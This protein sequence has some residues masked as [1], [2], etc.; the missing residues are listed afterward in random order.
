MVQVLLA[1]YHKVIQ[2][3]L[4]QGLHEPLGVSV[5]VRTLRANSLDRG[6]LRVTTDSK[7]KGDCGTGYNPLPLRSD[8]LLLPR[9]LAAGRLGRHRLVRALGDGVDS[10]SDRLGRTLHRPGRRA[11]QHLTQNFLGN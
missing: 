9:R 11:G 5:P 3:L 2:A 4:T 8:M 6:C 10:G 1:T 7:G